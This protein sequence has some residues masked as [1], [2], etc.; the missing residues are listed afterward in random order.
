MRKEITMHV[1]VSFTLTG[2]VAQAE[3]LSGIPSLI[4]SVCIT[5]CIF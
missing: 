2:D 1:P 4:S 5:V 3:H